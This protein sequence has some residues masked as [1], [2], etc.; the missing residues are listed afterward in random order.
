MKKAIIGAG[1]FGREL[2]WHIQH[3]AKQ[4]IDFFV[5]E[6]FFKESNIYNVFPLSQFDPS[7]W[8][9][10]VAISNIK[11]RKDIVNKLPKDIHFFSYID[12]TAHILDKN[13]IIKENSIICNGV[14]LTTNIQLGKNIQLNLQTTI[15]HDCII[16]NYVTTAPGVRISGNCNIGNEVYLGTNAVVKEG[17]TICD[18]VIIGMNAGVTKDIIIPG[19]YIGTPTKLI[20]R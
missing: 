12:W 5:D 14:I 18:N 6:E 13:I 9:V 17:I 11:T 1:G 15:G 10:V 16:G 7:V 4:N 20:N 19:T 3:N 8:E 2:Y